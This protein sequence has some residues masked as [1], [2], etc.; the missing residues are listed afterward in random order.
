MERLPSKK[1]VKKI[2]LSDDEL[3]SLV[4][5]D[6][7]AAERFFNST[8]KE[9]LIARY[10]LL[11]AN[12]EYYDAIFPK[13]SKQCKFSSSDVK[14]IVE[15]L[16]PSL[17]E[18]YFG[19][20]NVVGVF[21]RSEKDNPEVLEKV[22]E[23]Q[24]KN[25]NN[26]YNVLDQW[27]RDA[28]EG[29]LGVVMMKWERIE[30]E[31]KNWYLC[32]YEEFVSLPPEAGED[33]LKTEPQPDGSY[34]LQVRETEILKNEVVLKNVR[35]GEFIYLK[36]QNQDGQYM[37]EAYRRWVPFDD[38]LKAIDN[39][40]YENVDVSN[41][42]FADDET[43]DGNAMNEVYEAITNYIDSDYESTEENVGVIEG[44]EA[45][46]MVIL[47]DHY[48]WYD[49]DGD[50]MLEFVHVVTCNGCLLKKELVNYDVSPFF[51]I[52]FYAN[53]YQRW[54]EAV[55]DYLQCVQDLKTALIRQLIVN[56]AQN[57]NRQF[58]I[59]SQ[60][61]DGI[62]DIVEGHE[63]IRINTTQN[64]GINDF[65]KPMPQYP[66]EPATFQLLE[67]V[68][69]WSEQ[70]TGITK[71]NQGL[72]ADSLNKTATGIVKIMAASQQRL[73]KMAR[74]GAENG[75]IPLYRHLIE[76]DKD[77]LTEDFEFR[78]T[79][80]YYQFTPD[81]I[82]GDYD[83]QIT[84][85]IGLQDKQLT[86]QNLMVI[87][88]QILPQLLQMGVANPIGVF[89]TAKECIKKMGFTNAQDYL[90]VDEEQVQA[91]MDL[92]NILANTLNA[93]G[94]PPETVNA[95]IQ[96]VMLGLQNPQAAQQQMAQ[97]QNEVAMA[98]S[99]QMASEAQKQD[100]H[101]LMNFK[102][103]REQAISDLA[104]GKY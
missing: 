61:I 23:Y 95:I 56:T 53:S 79:D 19:A 97:A 4:C 42:S 87:L 12:N 15:W 64:R 76:L 91:Q 84:S 70:K 24:M 94:L 34:K 96:N 68:D 103:E 100:K 89:N 20:D 9:N 31:V 25:Q 93:M 22:L 27:C 3:Y 10:N 60:S 88:S 5:E 80:K 69:S 78:L 86:V 2:K 47:Y 73:R 41:F 102:K 7:R 85:N 82:K 39:G 35:P 65:I 18:V 92:P 66:L 101:K 71:Y 37:Y 17:T 38:I 32:T 74:D 50:G 45:R 104:G 30:K 63:F 83:V 13:L 57:N 98:E 48:G 59:D 72:D 90:G 49:V 54:K 99:E 1:D 55:A 62:K 6:R 36:N 51:T 26:A 44:Q 52:S 67:R 14:D 8:I 29:G 11:H 28:V 40:V 81:D 46:K 16:M 58:A 43:G 33:I 77:N 75:I 21:G